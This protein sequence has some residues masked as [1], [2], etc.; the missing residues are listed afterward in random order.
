MEPKKLVVGRCFF[1]FS[2]WGYFH[3]PAV[4]FR[5]CIRE[6][7]S[8]L[9]LH[10]WDQW[11]LVGFTET[12]FLDFFVWSGTQL[13]TYW[14][15][16]TTCIHINASLHN[17][18]YLFAYHIY[19]Y[20]RCLHFFEVNTSIFRLPSSWLKVC[21]LSGLFDLY[22]CDPS[23][24]SLNLFSAVWMYISKKNST[25]PGPQPRKSFHDLYFGVT[26]RG[27]FQ[28]PVETF[29]EYWVL[30][31]GTFCSRVLAIWKQAET[32]DLFHGKVQ[33]FSTPRSFNIATVE[34]G[35]DELPVGLMNQT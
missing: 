3:V 28:G 20:Y 19:I 5:G 30:M 34:G 32:Q 8:H 14:I 29:L 1:S 11:R 26:E 21:D 9:I 27:M 18:A 2:F 10:S 22:H 16:M 6:K 12:R 4:S 24:G 25:Y 33:I 13:T 7:L 17:S 31:S 15:I 23:K 35:V